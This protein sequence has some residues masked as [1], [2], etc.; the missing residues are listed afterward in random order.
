MIDCGVENTTL[1]NRANKAEYIAVDIFNNYHT[2]CIGETITEM[3]EYL[4]DYST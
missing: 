1:F 3:N 4:K 2:I